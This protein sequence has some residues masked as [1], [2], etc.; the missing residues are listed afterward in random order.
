MRFNDSDIGNLNV[1]SESNE[2]KD[3]ANKKTTDLPELL[4]KK[5]KNYSYADHIPRPVYT[6]SFKKQVYNVYPNGTEIKPRNPSKTFDGRPIIIDAEINNTGT[7]IYKIDWDDDSGDGDIYRKESEI[8]VVDNVGKSKKISGPVKGKNTA[9]CTDLDIRQGRCV[10]ITYYKPTNTPGLRPV[11]K[12]IP[13]GDI[14]F[15]KVD[16]ES[17]PFGIKHLG[18]GMA[19]LM[20]YITEAASNKLKEQGL[21]GIEWIDIDYETD[22]YPN[23]LDEILNNMD[24][25]LI[26][27]I[28]N[29]SFGGGYCS[30]GEECDPLGA[31]YVIPVDKGTATNIE[32]GSSVLYD[33]ALNTYDKLTVNKDVKKGDTIVELTNKSKI[34]TNEVIPSKNTNAIMNDS[35]LGLSKILGG[36]KG[37]GKVKVIG[38]EPKVN[39]NLFDFTLAIILAPT[40]STFVYKYTDNISS[41]DN[42]TIVR[43]P[44]KCT[45]ICAL[46][47]SLTFTLKLEEPLKDNKSY[48]THTYKNKVNNTT[49]KYYYIN[50]TNSWGKVEYNI[51]KKTP[52]AINLNTFLSDINK[53][54]CKKN[55]FGDIYAGL[56]R[57]VRDTLE[58]DGDTVLI[59]T[60]FCNLLKGKSISE[61][62]KK[63]G[64]KRA[65]SKPGSAG[66][67]NTSLNKVDINNIFNAV[68][69]LCI[70]T[71]LTQT[72][73]TPKIYTNIERSNL[74][75]LF[76]KSD[77]V[78]VVNKTAKKKQNIKTVIYYIKKNTLNDDYYISSSSI[79][80]TDY[81]GNKTGTKEVYKKQNSKF[82]KILPSSG[83][84]KIS[85]DSTKHIYLIKTTKENLTIDGK[86]SQRYIEVNNI[87]DS[88][89]YVRG[90]IP[91]II[92][93]VL[94][95]LSMPLYQ[96]GL[97]PRLLFNKTQKWTDKEITIGEYK[98]K[99]PSNSTIFIQYCL[100]KEWLLNKIYNFK[101]TDPIYNPLALLWLDSKRYPTLPNDGT[102]PTVRLKKIAFTPNFLKECKKI[103]G[104]SDFPVTET[105]RIF[106]YGKCMDIV[107]KVSRY[108]KSFNKVLSDSLKLHSDIDFI[109]KIDA[110]IDDAAPKSSLIPP[111][112]EDLVEVIQKK[113]GLSILDIDSVKHLEIMS[114]YKQLTQPTKEKLSY[115][116]YPYKDIFKKFE[117]NTK[118]YIDYLHLFKKDFISSY[119]I[120]GQTKEVVEGF[121]S[122]ENKTIILFLLC[123]LVIILISVYIK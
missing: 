88:I 105:L 118:T 64:G 27:P 91:G 60:N 15:D 100:E 49:Y 63:Y 45:Y 78:Y 89:P 1:Y 20:N 46:K 81:I 57:K 92:E 59:E 48:W 99:N 107:N 47:R 51:I 37:I 72:V 2:I 76:K 122:S 14:L 18:G 52:T 50:T 77:I 101:G 121:T 96:L 9:M 67:Y 62:N 42:K 79:N 70:T 38:T 44:T 111:D 29:M 19:S 71:P 87:P 116:L 22:R 53:D 108:T 21:P 75:F 98:H 43:Q 12:T 95:T 73:Y 120:S 114:K 56:G 66:P 41:E 39:V 65:P 23:G 80:S 33:K 25:A 35:M 112:N 69:N 6:G 117:D 30:I 61:L 28:K 24:T 82:K 115:I 103:S 106:Y 55:T 104:V 86:L 58:F 34:N 109:K 31:N 11:I 68:Q 26:T 17:L 113:F 36:I 119:K 123:F 85:Y 93:D 32:L 7:V 102:T 8:S 16:G 10:P 84:G 110:A 5:A 3:L 54:S 74:T 94:R 83:S 13:L 40:I 90:V 4:N 97:D